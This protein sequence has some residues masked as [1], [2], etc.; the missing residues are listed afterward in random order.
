MFDVETLDVAAA[1]EAGYE[2]ELVNPHTQEP[3]G[4]FVTVRGFDSAVITQHLALRTRDDAQRAAQARRRGQEPPAL[5]PDE[6]EARGREL[7]VLATKGWRL[8]RRGGADLPFSAEAARE[9]YQ[10]RIWIATQVL[11]QARDL[12]NFGA[13]PSANSS[14][15]DA[16]SSS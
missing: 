7:A 13:R 8:F 2:F 4:A 5:A 15:T 10:R 6:L 16:T 3:L 11:D 14:T 1:C 12:G 9:L